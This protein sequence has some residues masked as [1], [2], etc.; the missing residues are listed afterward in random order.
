MSLG[1]SVGEPSCAYANNCQFFSGLT[2]FQLH[3][4]TLKSIR[5][6]QCDYAIV[7]GVNLLARPQ[8]SF[9]FQKLGMLSQEG[10]CKSFDAG[11]KGYVRSETIF[12]Q[13]KSTCRRFY[14]KFL[15]A[16]V[17]TD[18]TKD[19]GISGEVQARLLK[20]IDLHRG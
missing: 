13:K 4:R 20:E 16:K 10:K 11:G 7:G 6:G 12:L 15:Q 9:Q 8:T 1:H 17:N 18:G 5:T 3:S 14:A 2:S 19:Q